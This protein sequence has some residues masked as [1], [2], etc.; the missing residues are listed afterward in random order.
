[1][2]RRLHRLG[3]VVALL[4]AS[5]ACHRSATN[6]VRRASGYVDAT[7]VRIAARVPGRVASVAV[8]E[9]MRVKAGD[10][11][12]TLSTDDVDLALG[13]AKAER[14]AA[15]AQLRL[16][17]AGARPEDVR[18]AE[19]QVEAASA[20][21][22]AADAQVASARADESR[23]AQLVEQH[24]GATKPLDDARTART[25]AEARAKAAGDHLAAARAALARVQAGARP[26]EIDAA[27]ARVAAADAQIATIEHDRAETR[28]VAP[29]AGIV[30]ARL[31][32]PGELVAVGAP[33]AVVTDLDQAWVNA[34]VEAPVVPTLRIQQQVTV[35]TDAGDRLAGTIAFIAPNA[36]FTPRNVQ[37]AAERARLVYRVK[38]TVDNSR[39]ILKPGMPVEVE[40]P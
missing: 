29:S 4:A 10:P 13:R 16:L 1:M 28:I 19:A 2:T 31:V 22:Q 11:V 15:D 17:Q 37:T 8:V 7:D 25:L 33:I 39:G 6:E 21:Q 40:L 14:A 35:V 3:L 27:R 38:V 30:T 20:D 18:Q 23:F 36:E 5:G 12:A 32:E 24:A 9:G 34:Y 26:Q